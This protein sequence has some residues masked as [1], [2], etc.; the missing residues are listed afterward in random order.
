MTIAS[1]RAPGRARDS[2]SRG[3]APPV[4]EPHQGQQPQQQ[5]VSIAP[6]S[7]GHRRCVR[8]SR[9]ASASVLHREHAL[10]LVVMENHHQLVKR[11]TVKADPSP[12]RISVTGDRR[13]PHE[14]PNTSA[15]TRQASW[16]ARRIATPA[17]REYYNVVTVIWAAA[18]RRHG[19][20]VSGQRITQHLLG[21]ER[22]PVPARRPPAAQQPSS[23]TNCNGNSLGR[24]HRHP[25]ATAP[26]ATAHKGKA[27]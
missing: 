4:I 23:V 8:S 17:R 5:Q 1:V 18:V 11:A 20:S 21:T 15:P 16:P 3:Y 12:A 13:L 14:T 7:C 9:S 19:W 24:Y 6:A 27:T 10:Q 25:A 26:A 2:A 22:Q